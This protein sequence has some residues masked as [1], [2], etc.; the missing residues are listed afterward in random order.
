[1]WYFKFKFEPRYPFA[2]PKICKVSVNGIR[3]SMSTV[4]FVVDS[5]RSLRTECFPLT[6]DLNDFKSKIN[7]QLLFLSSF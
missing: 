4:S 2:S 3:T 5:G 7:K 1:M 6:Y